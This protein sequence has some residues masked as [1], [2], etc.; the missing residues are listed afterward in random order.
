MAGIYNLFDA[1]PQRVSQW[2][3]TAW[4][5]VVVITSVRVSNFNKALD[6]KMGSFGLPISH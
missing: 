2:G 6:K 1:D 5:K 3:I 4:L